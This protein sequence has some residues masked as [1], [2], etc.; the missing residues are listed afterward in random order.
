MSLEHRS[1]RRILS[2]IGTNNMTAVDTMTAEATE[3]IEPAV[4]IAERMG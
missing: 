4:T 3:M 2:I 1:I